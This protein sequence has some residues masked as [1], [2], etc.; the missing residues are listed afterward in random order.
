MHANTRGL[1]E[2]LV[3]TN[4]D[5]PE[6]NRFYQTIAVITLNDVY[7]YGVEIWHPRISRRINKWCDTL[8]EAKDFGWI[9]GLAMY[10]LK[11]DG[12]NG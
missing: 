12:N 2:G 3:V 1:I 11:W 4:P 5:M 6:D 8:Q 9:N 10:G 7:G